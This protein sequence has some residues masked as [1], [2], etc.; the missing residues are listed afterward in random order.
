VWR[1][2]ASFK[3]SGSFELDQFKSELPWS[4]QIGAV[5]DFPT[6]RSRTGEMRVLGEGMKDAE[7]QQIMNR[8]ADSLSAIC[9]TVVRRSI[10]D[11]ANRSNRVTT[12]TV[13]SSRDFMRLRNSARSLRIPLAFRYEFSS[14]RPSEAVRSAI[15]ESVPAWILYS[16]QYPWPALLTGSNLTRF[17]FDTFKL[18]VC[19]T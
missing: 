18:L 8:L 3:R 7:T 16:S 17:F 12:T 13:P 9:F 1:Q 6:V 10:V 19:F 2:Q 5:I 4:A 11:R 15:P 14:N